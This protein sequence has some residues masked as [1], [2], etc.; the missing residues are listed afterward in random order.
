[1]QIPSGQLGVETRHIAKAPETESDRPAIRSHNGP[2]TLRTHS[3]R[4]EPLTGAKPALGG[5]RAGERHLPRQRSSCRARSRPDSADAFL[6]IPA[7]GMQ[8]IAAVSEAC[9]EQEGWLSG[10]TL[11]HSS[12]GQHPPSHAP[13]SVWSRRFPHAQKRFHARFSACT[14]P[15]HPR[16]HR[17]CQIWKPLLHIARDNTPVN[18]SVQHRRRERFSAPGRALGGIVASVP[19]RNIFVSASR[20][21][22]PPGRRWQP[23][24]VNARH[25][26][27]AERSSGLSTFSGLRQLRVTHDLLGNC[28]TFR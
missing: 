28:G 5:T 23:E 18:C 4:P 21:R 17:S 1:M 22:A 7:V 2:C 10:L 15:Q 20:H 12:C 27:T 9:A 8:T 25:R 19:S 24:A 26:D 6:C 16:L 13:K 11:P 3:V 14:W